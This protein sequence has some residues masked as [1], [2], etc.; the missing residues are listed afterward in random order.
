MTQ[1][2]GRLKRDS[3]AVRLIDPDDDRATQVEITDAAQELRT[4][5]PR[6]QRDNLAELREALCPDE[7]ACHPAAPANPTPAACGPL[8]THHERYIT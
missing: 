1:L 8:V 6:V 7:E 2:V 4:K 3:L 5:R